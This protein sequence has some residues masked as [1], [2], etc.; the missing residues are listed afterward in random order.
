MN[1]HFMELIWYKTLAEMRAEAARAY[2]GFLWWIV[3]PV[4]YMIAFYIVFALVFQ[5]GGEGYVP[6]L[7]CGLVVWKWFGS[8]VGF[9]AN[10]I[11]S[12]AGLMSQVYVPKY[13][14]PS[15]VLL[16]TTIKFL[17]ILLIF[18]LFLVI[19]GI[20]P[21]VTWVSLLAIIAIQFLFTAAVSGL[22]AS[23]VPI[24]PD[25]KL[26]L[27]NVLMLLFFLSGVFFDISVAPEQI[28]FYLMLNPVAVIIDAYRAVLLDGEWPDVQNLAVV[29]SLTVVALLCVGMI[30]KRYDRVYPK[31]FV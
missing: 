29:L 13:I 7:L 16:S 5:R 18:M 11:P 17:V 10:S 24:V 27:D 28:Q 23:M 6:F 26:I 8:A 15:V 20:S 2:L 3:E 21:S 19:Y 25:I 12:N 31:I 1:M 9:C 30:F 14:F 4:L 22:V